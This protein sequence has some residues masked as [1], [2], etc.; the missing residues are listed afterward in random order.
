MIIKDAIKELQS[1]PKATISSKSLNMFEQD[2][3]SLIYWLLTDTNM[4]IDYKTWALKSI[5]EAKDWKVDSK[6]K[7]KKK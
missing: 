6:S 2:I 7:K 3:D 4:D 5:L 1:N